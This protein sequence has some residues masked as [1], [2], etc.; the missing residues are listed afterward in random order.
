MNEGVD[1]AELAFDATHTETIHAACGCD[2]IMRSTDGGLTWMNHAPNLSKYEIDT[3]AIDPNTPKCLYTAAATFPNAHPDVPPIGLY[4]S[5]DSG[6]TW[7]LVKWHTQGD[8]Y[9]YPAYMSLPYAGWATSKI[10]VDLYDSQTLYMTNWYGVAISRDGGLTWDANHFL[11]LENICIENM[12]THPVLPD[13]VYMVSADHAPKISTDGGQTFASLPRPQLEKALPD[14]T[15]L[16][17]SRFEPNTLL[18][19]IKGSGGCSIVKAHAD[20][21]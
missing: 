12:V 13:T 9:N 17:A 11:G 18:Y 7:K 14:S 2:G 6:E 1:F 21:R 15:A 8:I 20:G 5:Q 19:A 4:Q 3:L 16:V 10:R